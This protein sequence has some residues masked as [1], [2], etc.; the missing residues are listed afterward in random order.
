ML[1]GTDFSFFG[2]SC[3][4]TIWQCR[5]STQQI[6]RKWRKKFY[7]TSDS[8]LGCVTCKCTDVSNVCSADCRVGKHVQYIE[9]PIRVPESSWVSPWALVREW[10]CKFQGTFILE[11]TLLVV[12]IWTSSVPRYIS[13]AVSCFVVFCC[14]VGKYCLPTFCSGMKMGEMEVLLALAHLV[15]RFQFSWYLHNKKTLLGCNRS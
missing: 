3:R 2:T 9:R 8:D 12:L 10:L 5:P 13:A 7:V 1:L 15:L 6:N 11:L 14:V 4:R